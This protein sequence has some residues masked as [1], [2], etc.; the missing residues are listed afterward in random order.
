[1]LKHTYLLE[2][3]IWV[4][5][6]NY[7]D[8]K[9]QKIPITGKTEIIHQ[10]EFWMIQSSMALNLP[11][12]VILTSRFELKPFKNGDTVADWVSFHENLGEIQGEFALVE[13]TILSEFSGVEQSVKGS[14][15]LTQIDKNT[16][17]S[18]GVFI[19]RGKKFSSWAVT[20]KRESMV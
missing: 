3:G 8:Q 1:M 19:L 2:S 18:R 20:L 14:E 4:S 5:E 11:D 6:G 16:Y 15:V 7:Y 10:S 12:Q 17:S 9:E 13:D